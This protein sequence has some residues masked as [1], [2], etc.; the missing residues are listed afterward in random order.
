MSPECSKPEK[1]AD[2][3]MELRAH[4][5]FT[6]SRLHF[7]RAHKS[8]FRANLFRNLKSL[9]F[10]LLGRGE[11]QL[12]ADHLVDTALSILKEQVATVKLTDTYD[13][14]CKECP[15]KG[16]THCRVAGRE[17]S[18]DFLS[19]VDQAVLRNTEGVLELGK[20]YP[21]ASFIENM[22]VIRSAMIKTLLKL[23]EIMTRPKASM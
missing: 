16:N 17:W 15:Q 4:H 2:K 5:L 14:V 8:E 23:P 1:Q 18:E 12:F 19:K 11:G 21:P 9:Q 3:P 7:F 20:E 10:K 6:L 22:G 13:E